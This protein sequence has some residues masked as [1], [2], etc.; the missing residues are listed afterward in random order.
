M[1]HRTVKLAHDGW[2]NV[3]LSPLALDDIHCSSDAENQVDTVI[4]RTANS[5][6]GI[7]VAFKGG[8]NQRLDLITG[9]TI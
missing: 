5:I 2:P 6:N 8:F 1:N 3:R 9:Q 7:T 4:S